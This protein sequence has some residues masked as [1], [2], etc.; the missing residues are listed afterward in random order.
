MGRPPR[1]THRADS[2]LHPLG[3]GLT[4]FF[5]HQLAVDDGIEAVDIAAASPQG[6]NLHMG[7]QGGGEGVE[8]EN[9]NDEEE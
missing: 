9:G 3:L 6:Q 7:H 4:R 2:A 8:D 5:R 1:R